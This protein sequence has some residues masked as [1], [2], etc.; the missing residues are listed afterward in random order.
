MTLQGEVAAFRDLPKPAIRF[1]VGIPEL[2][3]LAFVDNTECHYIAEDQTQVTEVVT[4]KFNN[5]IGFV[6]T[7][8]PDDGLFVWFRF[9]Y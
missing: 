1:A 2:G 5:E 3:E 7:D 4:L 8:R 6:E 9:G